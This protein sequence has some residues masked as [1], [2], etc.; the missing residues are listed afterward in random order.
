M[1]RHATEYNPMAAV[2]RRLPDV[3]SKNLL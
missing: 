1:V 3:T 2:S